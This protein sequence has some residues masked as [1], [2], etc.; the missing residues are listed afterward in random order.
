[1]TPLEMQ[2]ELFDPPW[3]QPEWQAKVATWIQTELIRLGLRSISQPETV[4]SRPWSTVLKIATD[5]GNLFFKAGGPTQQFEP[6]LLGVLNARR[7]RHTLPLLAADPDRGWSLLPDGGLTLRQLIQGKPDFA[8]WSEIL[9][10]YAELQIEALQWR[11][12]FKSAGVPERSSE[13]LIHAYT[14]ILGDREIILIAKSEGFLNPEQYQRLTDLTPVIAEMF[15]ELDSYQIPISLEHG[16]LHDANIFVQED[17]Y[18]IFDWGDASITHPFFTLLLPVRHMAD[19]LG[20]S[21]YDDR[22]EL[23]SLVDAYLQPWEKFATKQRLLKAWKL[24][25]HLAKFARTINWYRVVKST[26]PN[27]VID[28]QA[29]ISGWFLEFL[30]HPLNGLLPMQPDDLP[31][32]KL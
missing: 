13:Y 14:E 3:D 1:M 27:L 16:D 10:Q 24:A 18:K 9:R 12:V 20:I 5:A 29:S 25:H 31:A 4:H 15:N 7:G 28:H 21:E 22:P 23:T 30:S 19:K 17:G 32:R 26:V 11:T 8:A 6:G 2:S